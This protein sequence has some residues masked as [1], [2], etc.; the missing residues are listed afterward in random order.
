MADPRIICTCPGRHPWRDAGHDD[1]VELTTTP[2]HAALAARPPLAVARRAVTARRAHASRWFAEEH[3]KDLIVL[4]YTEGGL[5]TWWDTCTARWSKDAPGTAPTVP[6]GVGSTSLGVGR[7]GAIVEYF[8][9]SCWSHHA[10]AG[11]AVHRRSIGIE[12]ANLG[13]AFD[14]AAGG[15]RTRCAQVKTLEGFVEVAALPPDVRRVLPAHYAQVQWGGP[16]AVRAWHGYPDAQL[17][18][19]ADLVD[20]LCATFDIPRMILPLEA[21]LAE[22]WPRGSGA[23]VARGI[24]CHANFVHAQPDASEKWDVGPAFPWERLALMIGA[25]VAPVG[26]S[27]VYAASAGA[28]TEARLVTEAAR[29]DIRR[30]EEQLTFLGFACGRA[31]GVIDAMT[32]AGV[33]RFQAAHADRHAVDGVITRGLVEHVERMARARGWTPPPVTVTAPTSLDDV[34]RRRALLHDI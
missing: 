11:S 20:A 16:K 30:L 8:P 17:A 29:A 32:R 19:L 31:D 27:T 4:H 28:P 21:R 12:L 33:S 22:L 26:A 10:T 25:T 14:L 6:V 2:A 34:R 7:D 23:G 24:V 13:W 5:P 1:P 9:P 15:H 18:A 3:P